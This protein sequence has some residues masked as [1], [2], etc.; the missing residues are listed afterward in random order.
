[1]PKFANDW[2]MNLA[3]MMAYSLITAIFPILLTI[4][5]IVG[6]VLHAFLDRHIDDL[7]RAL[8]SVF[9]GRLHSVIR[10]AGTTT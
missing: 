5:S 6:I 3:S 9:P 7:A 10:C 4:L 2:S 8:T 1:V